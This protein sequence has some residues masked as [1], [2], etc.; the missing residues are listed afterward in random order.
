M[1]LAIFLLLISSGPG[2]GTRGGGEGEQH[3]K[4]SNTVEMPAASKA[5]E[6]DS[7][8]LKGKWA[9]TDGSYTLEV[10]S[11]SDGGKADAG[12]FNPNPIHVG[13]AEWKTNEGRLF[14]TVVLKDVNYPG[15]TYTLEYIKDK[16]ILAGNY[17]QA[18]EGINYDVSFTRI[19]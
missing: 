14:L 17:F 8:L 19:K 5:A 10:F 3:E 11:L 1:K 16:D 6:T 15:S 12:Y 7:N 9:R 13:S 4:A 2:C 18:V